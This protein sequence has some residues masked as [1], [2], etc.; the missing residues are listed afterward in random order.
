MTSNIKP[1]KTSR[2]EWSDN[3]VQ[4][5][6]QALNHAKQI[7]QESVIIVMLGRDDEI[8]TF[9]SSASRIQLIGALEYAKHKVADE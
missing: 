9:Y 8:N 2:D 4:R 3:A 5:I 7:P 1:I 6:E